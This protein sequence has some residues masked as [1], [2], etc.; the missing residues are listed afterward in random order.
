MFVWMSA[1]QLSARPQRH[2][3][4]FDSNLHLEVGD[5]FLRAGAGR[6][7]GVRDLLNS[8]VEF[9]IAISV[10][11]DFGLVA[12]LHIHDVVFVHVYTRFHVAE[13]GHA[14]HFRAGELISRHNAFA[15]FAVENCD[16]AVDRRINRRLGKLIARLARAGFGAL[17]FVQ[18]TFV[19]I[20]RHVAGRLRRVIFLTRNQSFC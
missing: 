5:F 14:H 12:E 10:D 20:L 1:V 11:L 4:V 13:V 16:R 8:S 6:L 18:R 19:G 2:V 9:P 7:P 17:D 15:Q 3:V